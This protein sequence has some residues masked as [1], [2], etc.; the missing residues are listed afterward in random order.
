MTIL[1]ERELQDAKKALEEISRERSELRKKCEEISREKAQLALEIK[2]LKDEVASLSAIPKSHFDATDLMV[3]IAK[4]EKHLRD[5]E[6]YLREWDEQLRAAKTPE[7]VAEEVETAIRELKNEYILKLEALEAEKKAFDGRKN[8]L[9]QLEETVRHKSRELE[10]EASRVQH[11]GEQ[12]DRTLASLKAFEESIK[13]KY[14]EL[15]TSEKK[16]R[17]ESDRLNELRLKLDDEKLALLKEKQEMYRMLDTA[18]KRDTESS[19]PGQQSSNLES[20][21][22][23]YGSSSSLVEVP[24]LSSSTKTQSSLM[25]ENERLTLRVKELEA[26]QSKGEELAMALVKLSEDIRKK[27]QELSNREDAVK[28]KTAELD[29]LMEKI[30]RKKLE[31]ERLER[32]A[33]YKW[34]EASDAPDFTPMVWDE[35]KSRVSASERSR[36][37]LLTEVRTL[38]EKFE[39]RETTLLEEITQLNKRVKEFD[40]QEVK[41]KEL[42]SELVKLSEEIERSQ[43]ELIS[44]KASLER[45]EADIERRTREFDEKRLE[46]ERK[47]KNDFYKWAEST[48]VPD[49]DS[50]VWEEL[51]SRVENL[52]AERERL[53]TDLN[54]ANNRLKDTLGQL[55][56]SEAA[57]KEFQKHILKLTELLDAEK[58]RAQTVTVSS[59]ANGAETL[60]SNA[61]SEKLASLE[62]RVQL[63]AAEESRLTEA[64]RSIATANAE[65]QKFKDQAIPMIK[66]YQALSGTSLLPSDPDNKDHQG[67]PQ[68]T[69]PDS[70]RRIL[71]VDSRDQHSSRYE[72]DRYDRFVLNYFPNMP[73]Q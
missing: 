17:T 29:L 45:Q 49:T 72:Q 69:R 15:E 32:D 22:E 34:A 55:E 33:F 30:D 46:A 18:A 56:D 19:T 11:V 37:K 47:E 54:S 71:A 65:L 73:K 28:Q 27:D 62:S 10:E 35:M 25:Q 59:P 53:R 58:K 43:R 67:S 7:Q 60:S 9:V 40:S 70:G 68:T 44:R 61:I 4:R 51:K 5:K 57:N 63:M 23:F 41:R 2:S 36:E 6:E 13:A 50:L 14:S 66:E 8:E 3:Q 24:D 21:L 64:L 31:A 52:E 39:A 20:G 1:V 26:E 12:A 48:G 38:K 16:V 42:A